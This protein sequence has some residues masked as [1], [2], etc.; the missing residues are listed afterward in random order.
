MKI[1]FHSSNHIFDDLRNEWDALLSPV[2]SDSL[3]LT[4]EWQKLWWDSLGNGALSILTVR[5]ESNKLI[6]IAPWF[7][8]SVENIKI[9]RTIGCTEVADYLD[10]IA[11][12]GEEFSVLSD[13]LEF[14]LSKNA[15]DWDLID[16]CN[17][18]HDSFTLSLLPPVAQKLGLNIQIKVQ[19]LCPIIELPATFNDCL[20]ML[21]RTRRQSLRRKRKIMEAL[22]YNW[23]KVDKEYDFNSEI[24]A[25]LDLMSLSRPDKA[26]FLER[27]GMRTFFLKMGK[28]MFEKNAM[29]LY[30]LENKKKRVAAVWQ[31]VCKDR[32]MFYNSGWNKN[33]YSHLSPG[34]VLLSY[35]I[36]HAIQRGFRR[37][38]FLRGSEYYKYR[39]GGNDVPVYNITISKFK[40]S[41]NGYF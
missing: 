4:C 12:T 1:D 6:G 11:E 27:P 5:N 22:G 7:I 33:L 30:F 39:L 35:C 15:P 16:L 3:F 37:Y 17:I 2:R 19:D 18:P 9:V 41:S 28:S 29:E 24:I 26:E 23:Y 40:E 34:I 32:I 25:F 21:N 31:F 10:V 20:A 36:E 13:L 14:M 38:D 8:E